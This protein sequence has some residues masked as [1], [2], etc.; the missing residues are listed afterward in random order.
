MSWQRFFLYH[1]AKQLGALLGLA[2]GAIWRLRGRSQ[3]WPVVHPTVRC[4]CRGGR[5]EL[6]HLTKLSRRVYLEA[7]S[8]APG[9]IVP[10]TIGDRTRIWDDTR[11]MAVK[12]ISIGADCAISWNCTILDGDRHQLSFDG[13]RFETNSAPVVIEDHVWIGCNVTVLKG[14]T[15]GSGAVIA[16]GSVVV[17]DI[18]ARMLAAGVPAKVIKP[19]PI[20]K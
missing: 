17:R 16:A 14:V 8:S 13:E 20:W 11:I 4:L 18:P 12:S 7:V 9:E 2:R 10:L 6:G 15:I 5:I 3:G 1:P 19:V